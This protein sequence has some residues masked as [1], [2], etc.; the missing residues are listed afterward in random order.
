M[1]ALLLVLTCLV[2]WLMYS[3]HKYD[4]GLLRLHVRPPGHESGVVHGSGLR[5]SYGDDYARF[6][7]SLG[8]T[9]YLCL[10]DERTGGARCGVFFVFRDSPAGKCFFVAD[11][12]VREEQRGR[13]LGFRFILGSI[14]WPWLICPRM[15]ALSMGPTFP[16]YLLWFRPFL[17]ATHVRFVVV[18]YRTLIDGRIPD[19]YVPLRVLDRK[20]V[21]DLFVDDKRLDVLHLCPF[22]APRASA[23]RELQ[24]ADR[25]RLFMMMLLPGEVMANGVTLSL[26]GNLL[27][28]AFPGFHTFEWLGSGDL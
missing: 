8:R 4:A 12:R 13:W 11:Y 26:E 2:T 17:N 16:R 18:S 10:G 24:S 3:K 19:R 7:R 5:V 21:K 27:H 28:T 14:A 15:Y 1:T 22:Q 20:G 23:G 9:S 6:F 25:H